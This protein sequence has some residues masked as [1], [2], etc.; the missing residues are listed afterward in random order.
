MA[1]ADSTS[2]NLQKRASQ[3]VCYATLYI[4]ATTFLSEFCQK[5]KKSN[6]TSILLR[7]TKVNYDKTQFHAYRTLAVI[8]SE[9]DIKQLADSAQITAVFITYLKQSMSVASRGRRLANLLFNLK[10]K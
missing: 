8:L 4:Y 9:H 1:S 7:L 3:L 2:D 6:T 5:L 10:S